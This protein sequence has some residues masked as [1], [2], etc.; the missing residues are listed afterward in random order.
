MRVTESPSESIPSKGTGMVTV[1]PA[2]AQAVTSLGCGG[3][4]RSS[5]M[6]TTVTRTTAE[7]TLPAV[8]RTV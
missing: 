5:S 1:S 3:V 6:A 2:T 4:L 7:A 8:S